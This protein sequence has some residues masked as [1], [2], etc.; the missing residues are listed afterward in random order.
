MKDSIFQEA[1]LVSQQPTPETGFIPEAPPCPYC[2]TLMTQSW[3]LTQR[4]ETPGPG[5]YVQQ[6]CPNCGSR[7]PRIKK[8]ERVD[9]WSLLNPD[10]RNQARLVYS[11]EFAART[12]HPSLDRPCTTTELAEWLAWDARQTSYAM[13]DLRRDGKVE[14]MRRGQRHYWSA[15]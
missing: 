2:A 1:S 10:I 3:E 7:G 11:F 15:K 12:S 4:W 5:E 13:T 8:G 14:Y 9:E 6:V